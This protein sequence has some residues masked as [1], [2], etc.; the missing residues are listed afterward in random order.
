MGPGGM[1][2]Q[3]ELD[4]TATMDILKASGI[5]SGEISGTMGYKKTVVPWNILRTRLIREATRY[6]IIRHG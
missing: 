6:G 2:S 3:T 5:D 1:N 4:I